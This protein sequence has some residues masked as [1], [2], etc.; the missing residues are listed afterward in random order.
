V[1][2]GSTTMSGPVRGSHYIDPADV[3]ADGSCQCGSR[4]ELPGL[5]PRDL[6]RFKSHRM[7][8]S[9]LQRSLSALRPPRAGVFKGGDLRNSTIF[10]SDTGGYPRR[11]RYPSVRRWP[12]NSGPQTIPEAMAN[13]ALA[14]NLTSWTSSARA[15][16]RSIRPCLPR[17]GSV[18]SRR[19]PP[20][21]SLFGA[22][23]SKVWSSAKQ[24]VTC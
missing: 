15:A 5:P 6:E 14:V 19:A 1:V 11:G 20:S 17:T 24:S 18:L 4:R 13:I 21:R 3:A 22:G 12:L 9:E 16:L 8:A 7:P 2:I 10:L 23:S